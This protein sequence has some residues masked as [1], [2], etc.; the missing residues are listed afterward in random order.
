MNRRD[1]LKNSVIV[2]ATSLAPALALAE[3]NVE[4]PT[5]T[6]IPLTVDGLVEQIRYDLYHILKPHLFTINDE[7]TRNNIEETVSH[8]L[9]T[10]AQHGVITDYACV[11]DDS[12]ST[13]DMRQLIGDIAIQPVSMTTSAMP[14]F[15]KDEGYFAKDGSVIDKGDYVYI[16][17]I[18]KTDKPKE[19]DV[20]QEEHFA[21]KLAEMRAKF[22]RA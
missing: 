5:P 9:E 15:M 6:S 20:D 8:Y 18:M 1:F 4:S 7:I 13:I 12:P 21:Q 16:P 3:M 2:T 17:F 22:G 19:E 14:A 11:C 10:Y